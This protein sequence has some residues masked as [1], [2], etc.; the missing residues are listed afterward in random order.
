MLNNP[1][2]NLNQSLDSENDELLKV[3][4]NPSSG[5]FH[6]AF[7]AKSGAQY[8]VK[9]VNLQGQI[10][11]AERNAAVK[12]GLNELM[13]D[14]TVQAGLYAVILSKGTEKITGKLMIEQLNF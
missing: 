5:K 8:E 11:F 6:L 3:F 13:L 7:L 1:L 4:P 10:V 2:F 9:V 12:N 14:L